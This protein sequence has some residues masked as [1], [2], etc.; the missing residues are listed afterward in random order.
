MNKRLTTKDFDPFEFAL[1]YQ[2]LKN[3]VQAARQLREKYG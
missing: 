1:L 2:K 3:E